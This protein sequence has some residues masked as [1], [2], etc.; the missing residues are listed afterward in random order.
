MNIRLFTLCDG[1][2]NY[3]GKLTV[4]GT[5]DNIKVPKTPCSVDVSLA[6]KVSFS[7]DENGQKKIKIRF[8]QANGTLLLPEVVLNP[9]MVQVKK[10]EMGNIAFAG[11]FHGINIPLLG[12]YKVELVVN[13]ETFTLPFKVIN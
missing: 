12:N 4:V 5:I 10:D 2:F 7:S 1:G 3:N 9:T 13:D 11:T 8:A 6:I